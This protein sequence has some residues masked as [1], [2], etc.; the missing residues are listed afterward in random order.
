M[1]SPLDRIEDEYQR[2]IRISSS[3]SVRA[4]AMDVLA[5]VNIA[6]AAEVRVAAEH[7]DTCDKV[8]SESEDYACT[9]GHDALREALAALDKEPA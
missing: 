1:S 8:L 7:N 5:L 2:I 6:R 4:D 9:C 3:S